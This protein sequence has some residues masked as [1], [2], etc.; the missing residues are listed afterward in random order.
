[1]FTI[2]ANI[3]KKA[4]LQPGACSLMKEHRTTYNHANGMEPRSNLVANLQEMK[5]SKGHVELYYEDAIDKIQNFEK[6]SRSSSLNSSTD[7]LQ[8]KERDIKGNS[9]L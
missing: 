2:A 1:M 5:R 8:G 4:K 9:G 3:K 7:K 6:L